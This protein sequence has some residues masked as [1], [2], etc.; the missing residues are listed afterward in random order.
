MKGSLDNLPE[1]G[2][3]IITDPEG[4]NGHIQTLCAEAGLICVYP[5]YGQHDKTLTYLELLDRKRI[6]VVSDGIEGRV[7]EIEE[8]QYAK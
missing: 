6:R 4:H 7:Y 5:S 8:N 3:V 1:S 2:A